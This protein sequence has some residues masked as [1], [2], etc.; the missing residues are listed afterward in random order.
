MIYDSISV[1][2]NYFQFIDHYHFDN[3]FR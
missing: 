3:A 1:E 2:I